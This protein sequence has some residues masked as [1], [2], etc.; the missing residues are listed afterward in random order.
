MFYL[1]NSNKI[2]IVPHANYID[3][4]ENNI[5]RS[6]ARRRLGVSEK[7]VVLLSLGLIRPYK[8]VPELIDAFKEL[9]LKGA[10]LLIAG[11]PTSSELGALIRQK[12]EGCDN[13]KLIPEFIPDEEIQSYMN[14][15][16]VAVFAF[17]DI[18]TSGSVIL[19]MSFGRAC[20]APRKGC[21]GDVLDDSG[22]FFY[23]P[24][25]EK[26]L[27]KAL[28]NAIKNKAALQ[29]MGERN[30]KLVEQWNW[31]RIAQM[32]LGVYQHHLGR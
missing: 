24:D 8:G 17:R 30:R 6:E 31:S 19:A 1:K 28:I 9:S 4:Y 13:I 32:T 7:E 16:D 26:G 18:F 5:S 27:L 29:C 23:D 11:K 21:I 3:N 15:C 14:A 10:Y 20:I 12:A 22:A 25:E 2:F